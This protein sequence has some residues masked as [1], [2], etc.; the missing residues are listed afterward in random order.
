MI[1]RPVYSYSL[2]ERVTLIKCEVAPEKGFTHSSLRVI[3]ILSRLGVARCVTKI[4]SVQ[5]STDENSRWQTEFPSSIR[6][7]R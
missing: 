2:Y 7:P 6:V 4:S 5:G 3:S 1:I